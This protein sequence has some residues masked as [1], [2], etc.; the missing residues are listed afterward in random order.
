MII[1]LKDSVHARKVL[2]NEGMSEEEY[3]D[4]QL[5]A[6]IYKCSKCN[7]LF[8]HWM[9]SDA[10]WRASKFK[11]IV[12]KECFEKKVKHPKYFTIDEY[13]AYR[14]IDNPEHEPILRKIL[15]KVF[16]MSKDDCRGSKWRE[17]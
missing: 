7:E 11:N 5:G 3:I 8:P 2:R 9:T 4:S 10:R 17:L 15:A 12:C 6:F 13:L 1:Q 16:S 14:P